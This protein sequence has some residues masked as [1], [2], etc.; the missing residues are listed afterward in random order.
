MH[1]SKLPVLSLI[2]LLATATGCMADN[3]D[4]KHVETTTQSI[5]RQLTPEQRDVVQRFDNELHREQMAGEF[6]AG[7]AEIVDGRVEPT[8]LA[9]TQCREVLEGLWNI[10]T[11][12]CEE[13]TRICLDCNGNGMT[14]S[15]RCPDAMCRCPEGCQEGICAG[16]EDGEVV[17]KDMLEEL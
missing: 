10:L 15:W 4:H 1:T 2:T 7:H 3:T 8:E 12:T 16:L 13:Q 9:P 6:L 11:G 14:T 5:K 17:T